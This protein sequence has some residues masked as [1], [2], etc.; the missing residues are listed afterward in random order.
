MVKRLYRALV[1]LAMIHLFAIVGF[2]VYLFASGRLNPDRVEQLAGVLRGEFDKQEVAAT[3]PALL[4]EAPIASEE[5]I[6][7]LAARKEFYSLVAD[8]RV[9][10]LEDRGALDK[11]IKF[12]ADTLLE[13]IQQTKK[14]FSKTRQDTMDRDERAGFERQLTLLAKSDS[15]KAKDLLKDQFDQADVI[16]LLMAMDENRAKGIVNACKSDNDLIWIGGILNQMGR[17]KA[18]PTGGSD[19]DG[20]GANPR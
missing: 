10:E 12:E 18:Q 4:A 17:R 2:V 19:P 16:R 3:Q 15:R 13:E 14:D 7:R 5:E 6:R 9:R 8:R 1:L 20:A 11:R